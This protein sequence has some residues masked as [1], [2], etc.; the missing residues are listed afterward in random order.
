MQHICNTE[1]NI[2]ALKQ[3]LEAEPVFA[4]DIEYLSEKKQFLG[5]G[6][7]IKNHSFYIPFQHDTNMPQIA[8]SLFFNYLKDT[9]ESKTIL[10]AGHGMMGLELGLLEK[11]GV[12]VENYFDTLIAHWLVDE[13]TKQGLK[14]LMLIEYGE[15]RTKFKSLPKNYPLKI[16][17]EYC[18]LDAENTLQ[19]YN[20]LLPRL[21]EEKENTC[22]KDIEMTVIKIFLEINKNGIREDMP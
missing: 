6:I 22:F 19:L 10:K 5:L 20:T 21:Q 16:T 7:A 3:Q 14:D 2:E 17:A 18:M 1:E 4:Y 8:P 12:F 11:Y 13:N 9:F 15:V